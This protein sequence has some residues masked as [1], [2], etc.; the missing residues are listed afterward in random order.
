MNSGGCSPTVQQTKQVQTKS[1][2]PNSRD[3]EIHMITQQQQ[4]QQ[5]QQQLGNVIIPVLWMKIKWV[6]RKYLVS[7]EKMNI[8][9][10][11]GTMWGVPSY[12]V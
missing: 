4:Q 9:L 12:E 1:L 8:K 5:Q 7:L 10:D 6:I 3:F 11:Q 2:Y